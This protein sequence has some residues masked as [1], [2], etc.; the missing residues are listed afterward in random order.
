MEMI[1]DNGKQESGGL[2]FSDKENRCQQLFQRTADSFGGI[3]HLCTPGV[4]Q[5]VIFRDKEDYIYMMT[6]IAIC[7]YELPEIQIITFEVMSNHLHMLLCGRRDVIMTFFGILYKKLR[8]YLAKRNDVVNLKRFECASLI[9]VESLESM[10]NQIVYIN[11]NNYVVDPDQTPFSYPYGANSFYFS[12]LIKRCSEGIFGNLLVH[13]RRKLLHS[14]EIGYPESWIL[15]DGYISPVNYV[16]LDI[17]EGM[18]R[19]ARHYF[20]KISRDIESYKD[21]AAQLGESIYYTDDELLAVLYRICK[22]NY[23]VIGPSL[24]PFKAKQE[25]ARTLHFDYNADNAKIAR[26]LNL[27][28]RIVDEIFPLRR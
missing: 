27:D 4:G 19:D 13:D 14:R 26:L 23:K 16:R 24:L 8:I 5:P 28:R 3:W 2:T 12:P 17:G 7:S 10:R 11:R 1:I 22:Q 15:C 25:L 21:I 9:S 20:H 6:L 18:F